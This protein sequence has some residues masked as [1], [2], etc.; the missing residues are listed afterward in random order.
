MH[1][2]VPDLNSRQLRAVLAVAEY[3][4]FVAAAAALK[5]SQPA[6]TRTIKRVEAKLGV[7]LFTRSTREVAVTDAGKEF[8][9]LAEKLLNDLK[10]GTQSIRERSS[11]QRGRIMVA[12]VLSLA[13]IIVPNLIADFTR[14]FGGVEVHLREGLQG[15][16]R[17][18][19][20]GGV[21]DFGV[22]YVE[23]LP[24][25]FAAEGLG[26]D[27][28]RAVLPAGHPLAGSREVRLKALG[29]VPLISLPPESRTRQLVD[30]AAAAAGI[31]LHYAATANQLP[32]L[33]SLVRNGIGV[34]VLGASECPPAAE[35]NLVSR[36]VI[37][38]QI[39]GEIGVIRL[40]ERELAPAAAALLAVVR[41]GLG[42]LI[43]QSNKAR[44]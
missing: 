15:S 6:L 33:F 41:A 23:G 39:S 24:K 18:D 10:I 38:P 27:R 34:T 16:V 37:D 31:S 5:A 3:R 28:Y 42:G 12:S 19:V 25:L 17:D 14:R 22:A 20:R 4:S 21:A 7:M 35:R 1:D 13:K 44:R 8:A 11:E 40:R 26:R 36:P 2:A 29:N 9:A 30:R 32:T 43:A